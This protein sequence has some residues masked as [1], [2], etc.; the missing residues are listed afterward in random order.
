MV[1]SMSDAKASKTRRT[2][3]HR[4]E[5]LA[6]GIELHLGDCRDVIPTLGKVDAV[7]TDP[8]YGVEYSYLSFDDTEKAI[9]E[10]I[11]GWLPDCR[12]LANVVAF[13]TGRL[14]QWLYPR[15]SWILGWA[16]RSGQGNTPWGFPCYWPILVYGKDPYLSRS[17]GSRPDTFFPLAVDIE[18]IDHPCPKPLNV[19]RWFV[20]RVSVSGTIFDPFMG[21]GTTGVACVQLERRFIGIELEEKYFDIACH[22]IDRELRKPSFFTSKPKRIARPA[23]FPGRKRAV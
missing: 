21:S 4:V 2:V 13:S 19:W 11:D 15:P 8:P 20:D 17:L 16:T 5:H 23:F 9:I 7:V 12:R 14:T 6:E 22:R 1:L 18:E 10:L 3:K